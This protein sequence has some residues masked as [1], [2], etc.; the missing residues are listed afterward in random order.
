MESVEVDLG[1]G[2]EDKT[3]RGFV[4]PLTELVSAE[5]LTIWWSWCL[6]GNVVQEADR[7]LTV[8]LT[9]RSLAE[10][11]EG[12]EVRL[13]TDPTVE[14]VE[15]LGP[16]ERRP[17]GLV[18]A[19]PATG[20]MHRASWTW[21]HGAEVARGL[22]GLVSSRPLESW[23]QRRCVSVSPP[24]SYQRNTRNGRVLSGPPM[25]SKRTRGMLLSSP[26]PRWVTRQVCRCV[27]RQLLGRT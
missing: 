19:E 6:T 22:L 18:S 9:V 8:T 26:P 24:K 11:R 20:T 23:S 2:A 4:E 13:V 21:S 25:G 5:S 15:E 3:P 27:W 10:R 17:M 14:L 12:Q 1:E 7:P 16:V